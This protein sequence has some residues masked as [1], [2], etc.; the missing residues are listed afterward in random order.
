MLSLHQAYRYLNSGLLCLAGS[1]QPTRQLAISCWAVL[2][3]GGAALADLVKYF[4]DPEVMQVHL[5]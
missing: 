5:G 2:C 4:C 3:G 1:L